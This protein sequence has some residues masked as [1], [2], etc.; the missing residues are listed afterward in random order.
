M[1]HVLKWH[2]KKRYKQLLMYFCKDA[3]LPS[4]DL[5]IEGCASVVL[6]ATCCTIKVCSQLISE[7]QFVARWLDP[8]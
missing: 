5:K 1:M 4:G 2:P 8:L 7:T 3:A 6:C